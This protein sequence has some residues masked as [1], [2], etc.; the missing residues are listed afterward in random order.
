MKGKTIGFAL[1]GPLIPSVAISAI[2]VFA[3]EPGVS[4]PV[5]GLGFIIGIVPSTVAATIYYFIY[6]YH[7]IPVA[8]LPSF[9]RGAISGLIPGLILGLVIHYSSSGT[10]LFGLFLITCVVSGAICGQLFKLPNATHSSDG[11]Q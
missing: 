2:L 9:M 3:G 5:I 10:S 1:T 7:L 6:R 4:V 8:N 11:S